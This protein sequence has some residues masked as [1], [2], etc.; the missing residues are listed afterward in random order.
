MHAKP[1]L[2][3]PFEPKGDFVRLGDLGGYVFKPMSYPWPCCGFRVFDEPRGSFDIC[4]IC[5]WEDDPLQGA[6]PCT[7]RSAT[8]EPLVQAQDNFQFTPDAD[9][10]EC[11]ESGFRR[12]LQWRRLNM[13]ERQIFNGESSRVAEFPNSRVATIEEYYWNRNMV[14]EK[15]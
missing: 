7:G 4:P 11:A 10:D 2:R 3:V 13:N 1:D 14:Q 8:S 5:G 6:N 9:L 15:T 12:D